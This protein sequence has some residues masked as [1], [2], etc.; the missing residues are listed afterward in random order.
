ML[1]VKL[2][3][4]ILVNKEGR[5]KRLAV[6]LGKGFLI[7]ELFGTDRFV[8][9]TDQGKLKLRETDASHHEGFFDVI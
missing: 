3:L 7:V 5:L 9:T 2:R 1:P 4:R 6:S 8:F